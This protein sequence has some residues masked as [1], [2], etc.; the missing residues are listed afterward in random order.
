M[1]IK[2][3]L[4]HKLYL[5]RESHINFPDYDDEQNFYRAIASGNIDYVNKLSN[6][7]FN[8]RRIYGEHNG[9]LSDN[10]TTNRKYYFVMFAST[11]MRFCI[12]AGLDRE[13]AF[14]LCN[15]YINKADKTSNLKKI[16]DIEDA[17]II[18][19]TKRMN[20][21]KKLNIFSMQIT[22]CIDYIYENL[23]HKV[24]VSSIA[25]YLGMS[26]TYLSKL[27][28]KEV[29]MSLSTYIKEQRLIAAANMLI[30]TENSI[31]EISEYFVFSSQSHFT[32]AF[33]NKYGITPKKYR[34]EHVLQ[35]TPVL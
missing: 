8:Q 3:E 17:M 1:D 21:R 16:D 13:T 22:K 19:F 6:I 9:K 34:D 28:S 23:H 29:N 11:I 18:E 35:R 26:P 24:S 31:S 5:Q 27:F 30:Y 20:E 14:S 7:Y 15:I 25:E 2:K 32:T 10:P 4:N 33:Q 12:D